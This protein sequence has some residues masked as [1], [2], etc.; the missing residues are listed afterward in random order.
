MALTLRSVSFNAL[1]RNGPGR[2]RS[3]ATLFISFDDS[4]TECCPSVELTL[5][6]TANPDTTIADLEREA[7]EQAKVVLQQALK[8][9]ETGGITSLVNQQFEKMRAEDERL[10]NWSN[11]E[12]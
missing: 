8:A 12:Q 5:L 9:L 2:N 10:K 1:Q 7:T 11:G 4:E 3:W 6:Q